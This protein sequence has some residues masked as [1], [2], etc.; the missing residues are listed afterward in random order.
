M[1]CFT[2][3]KV[4]SKTK[5]GTVFESSIKDINNITDLGGT[6]AL[7]DISVSE[8]VYGTTAQEVTTL[9]Y[10]MDNNTNHTFDT[11]QTIHEGTVFGS[12][13]Q[14][15]QYDYY[16]VNL[17]AGK[18]YSIELKGMATG[19]DYDIVLMNSPTRFL[20]YSV[21]QSNYDEEITY[22]ISTTGI[23][24]IGILPHTYS[25]SSV[26]HNYQLMVYSADSL[27]DSFE[28]NDSNETATIITDSSVITSTININTDDDWFVLDTSKTG[29]LSVVMKSIPTGCDYDMQ[30]F[31]SDFKNLGGSFS[32]GNMDEKFDY[33]TTTPGKYFIRVYS[34]TGS[35][36]TDTYELVAGVY[37]ADQYELN[38]DIYTVNSIDR[39]LLSI[40]N[41]VSATIDNPDDVD[42]Y[43]FN[44]ADSTKVGA[45][46]INI[47]VG[48]DYDMVVYSYS[49]GSFTEVGRSTIGGNSDEAVVKQLA[50]GSYFIKVYSYTGSSQSLSYRLSLYDE[51]MGMI[52]MDVDKTT[53]AVGD[54]ITVIVKADQVTN[55]AGYQA[56]VKYDPAVIMPVDF[57]S[58]PFGVSTRAMSGNIL[59]NPEY[60]PFPTAL[61]DLQ[62]GILNFGNCYLNL[63]HIELMVLQRVQE[64]LPS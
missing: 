57:K 49:N 61:N 12:I 42:C 31:D 20:D 38:D 19:E 52:S 51:N 26:N 8:S 22:T 60:S 62:N 40:N 30:I 32:S 54:I 45:R 6:L 2:N 55:L 44:L 7:S 10:I 37:T 13:E 41:C 46:L 11:A 63:I 56:N 16:A 34:Y 53:A 33:I 25:S 24:Y 14:S 28:P 3:Y 5:D 39:P 59:V 21:N 1:S 36:P 50:P 27:P 15:G 18:T 4:S 58:N 23:Y 35:N 43:K 64:L 48:M 47:P 17:T 29:K 9:S